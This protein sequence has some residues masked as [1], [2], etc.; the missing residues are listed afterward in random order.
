MI[1]NRINKREENRF[2]VVSYKLVSSEI[3][4]KSLRW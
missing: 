4:E 3:K 2:E 1:G